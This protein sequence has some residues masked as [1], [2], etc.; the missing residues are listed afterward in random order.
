MERFADC[1]ATI[2]T[3][4]MTTLPFHLR[5]I[6]PD[7]SSRTLVCFDTLLDAVAYVS[8]FSKPSILSQQR[9]SSLTYARLVAYILADYHL[10][11]SVKTLATLFRKDDGTFMYGL[12]SAAHRYK[13][14]EWFARLVRHVDD[15]VR[16]KLNREIR[17]D[18][19]F[20][21]AIDFRAQPCR[22]VAHCGDPRRIRMARNGLST[23]LVPIR[24]RFPRPTGYDKRKD[25]FVAG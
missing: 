7:T 5:F 16:V 11:V 19:R 10:A 25:G 17:N 23:V 20:E 24:E 1:P 6:F 4:R 12:S 14:D 21:A 13:S 22:S 8:G 18:R 2:Q 15:A 9:G 3:T